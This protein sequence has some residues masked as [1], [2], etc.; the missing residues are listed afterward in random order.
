[1]RRQDMLALLADHIAA[2]PHTHPQ[3]V[4]IDGVDTAGKTT[5]AAELAPPLAHRGRPVIRASIDGFHRPRAERYRRGAAAPDGYYLDSF[6]Y[7]ALRDALLLPLGPAGSRRYRRVVF[8]FRTDSPVDAIEEEAPVD[9]ILLFDGVFLQ[10]PELVDLWDYRI[11][12]DVPFEVM[13]RRAIRRDLDLFGSVEAV[14][15]RYQQRYLPGQQL[16]LSQARP[17]EH[18]DVTLLNAD[19]DD[20]RLLFRPPH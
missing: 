18:A 12:V 9:A 6:D 15:A 8:D 17:R 5:L 14:A 10:C 19:P 7:P 16:Y 20:P 2:L 1:M 13:L 11:Y 3:R 4:A